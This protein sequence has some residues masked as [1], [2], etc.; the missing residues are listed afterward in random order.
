MSA[1]HKHALA[2]NRYVVTA[3]GARGW[4]HITASLFA[5]FSF[6]FDDRKFLYGFGLRLLLLSSSLSLLLANSSHHFE[7]VD[8]VASL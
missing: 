7:K 3:Y 8:I 4:L 1:R 2:S 5:V 6:N